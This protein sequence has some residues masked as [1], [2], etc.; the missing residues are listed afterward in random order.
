MK[1]PS[2]RAPLL[3]PIPYALLALLLSACSGSDQPSGAVGAGAGAAP[4]ATLGLDPSVKYPDH[5]E[6]EATL[7]APF[8]SEHP[9]GARDFT[10]QFSY[11]GAPSGSVFV[12]QLHL[13]RADGTEIQQWFGELTYAGQTQSVSVPWAGRVGAQASLT[14]GSYQLVLKARAAH[15]M[16]ANLVTG[17]AQQRVASMLATPGGHDPVEQSWAILLGNPPKP[18]MPVFA[19]MPTNRDEFTTQPAAGEVVTTDEFGRRVVSAAPA[20]RSLPYTVYYANL[21]SQT[22][23]SDGG[24]AIPG[25]TSSQSA[26]TGQFGPAAAFDYAKSA[27]LDVLATTEHNHYFDGSSGTNGS[28]SPTTAKNRYQAGLSVATSKSSSSFL[29]LYGMEW[30]VISNGGHLNIFNS[31]ELLAWETNSSG[32][33]LGDRLTPKSDYAALYAV[34]RQ[35]GLVG[36]FNHPESSGQFI[37]G[38]TALGYSADGD[39]VM[40]LAEI[41]GTSA[42]SSNTTETESS[43]SS[44]ETVYNKILERGFHVAPATNQDNHCANWGKAY[45][46]RTGVLIPNG[47]AL[48]KASFVD[49]LKARRVFATMDKNSQLVLQANGTRLMGER[50]TNS[51]PL[52]LSAGFA[53]TTGK[54]ASTVQILEGVPGRNGTVSVL[55]NAATAN[56]TPSIGQHFYYAKVTQN[57]GKILWS[58]PI[59]VT[60][61]AGGGS[62]DT[63][64]PSASATESGGFGNITLSATASDNIGVTR[65][66]FL[67][68]NVVKGSDTTAPYSVTFDSTQL[69]NGNH[70]LVARAYDA[71]GNSG[72]SSA[73]NFSINNANAT[74]NETESNGTIASANAVT[75]QTTLSGFMGSATDIDY[76]RI[77]LAA[78]R[79]LRIDMTGP[80]GTDYDLYVTNSS[81]TALASAE[82]ST[83]TELLNFTN[84]TSSATVY[85][86]VISYSGSSTTQRY[87]LNLSYP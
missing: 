16:V 78:N 10:M 30:G 77:T 43:R 67:I 64:P 15:P 21:H 11:P 68:D 41:L 84:G 54:T 5:F 46:N 22:N 87:T 63:T 70:T 12:W 27:G 4:A 71:A 62:T 80:S 6:F 19:A 45:T 48:T 38:G 25:C 33:L 47:T 3:R 83:S 39:E 58:A 61:V 18:A 52:S 50:I 8:T 75:T 59:W 86:K 14:D 79:R 49:A 81:G 55:A 53:S 40:V 82:S 66:D 73:V 29:A 37:V 56:V 32:Q 57:D 44:Y 76:Y 28:A 69:T 51:G 2:L 35:Q 74:L 31:N 17:S 72:A 36:Q 26:Q 7:E 65:V 42:F 9:A 85:I 24:G 13:Q 23:D 34:M 1:S 60:Q 20:T